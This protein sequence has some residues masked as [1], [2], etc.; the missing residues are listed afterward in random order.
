MAKSISTI[1]MYRDGEIATVDYNEY[2]HRF[3]LTYHQRVLAHDLCRVEVIKKAQRQQFKLDD[4]PIQFF[5][6]QG[7]CAEMRLNPYLNIWSLVAENVELATAKT[8][9][10]IISI[11]EST[12]G[13]E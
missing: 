4:Q 7:V 6:S 10:D 8:K 1:W 13:F 3:E 12:F 11:A 9:L 2:T 5:N